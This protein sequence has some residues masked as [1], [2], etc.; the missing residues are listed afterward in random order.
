MTKQ[1]QEEFKKLIKESVIEVLD[2][3]A[4]Q[5]VLVK[6]FVQGYNEMVESMLEDIWHDVKTIKI[7]LKYIKD[8]Y[9][10]KIERLERKVGLAVQ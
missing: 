4:G 3:K 6:S 9:G 10:T 2:S 1:E 7:E 5:E 8:Q